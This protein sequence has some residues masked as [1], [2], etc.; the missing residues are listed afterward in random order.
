MV[1][2][3]NVCVNNWLT[4]LWQEFPVCVDQSC[5]ADLCL[6]SQ[7]CPVWDLFRLIHSI[8]V[9]GHLDSRQLD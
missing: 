5:T 8:C 9:G 3:V 6:T 4:H 2:Q 1:E 7:N